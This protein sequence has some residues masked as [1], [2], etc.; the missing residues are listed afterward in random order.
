RAARAT[1]RRRDLRSSLRVT[2]EPDDFRGNA[3]VVVQV[4]HAIPG[5]APVD[6]E[7]GHARLELHAG[8]RRAHVA[9]AVAIHVER[10]VGVTPGHATDAGV[11][12]EDGHALRAV[13]Q[14]EAIHAR[15][16]HQD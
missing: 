8:G 5:R 7:A 13:E 16:L 15:G 10:L 6:D 14:A 12:L 11:A 9:D 2:L 3:T 1:G 4:D